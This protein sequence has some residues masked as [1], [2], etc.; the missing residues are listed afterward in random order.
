M[1]AKAL[2]NLKTALLIAERENGLSE[3]TEV[4]RMLIYGALDV[5]DGN[6]EFLSEDL[7][8]NQLVESF[9]HAT[10]HRALKKLLQD[11]FFVRAKGSLRNRYKLVFHT[12]KSNNQVGT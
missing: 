11:G 4:E 10:Y 3:L 9:P 2:L 1:H 5:A 12:S 6:H 7:R 8:S